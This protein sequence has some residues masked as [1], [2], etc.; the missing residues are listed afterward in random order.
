MWDLSVP[1]TLAMRIA[2]RRGE[3]PAEQP[4]SWSHVPLAEA[5]E[6]KYLGLWVTADGRWTRR[7]LAAKDKALFAL[8]ALL[9]RSNVQLGAKVYCIKTLLIFQN[10][11]WPGLDHLHDEG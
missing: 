1:K 5:T 7:L 10:E 11:A 3:A 4:P 6:T 8:D 9:A 2:Q